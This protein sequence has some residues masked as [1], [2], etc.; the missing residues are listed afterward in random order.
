MT[1][2]AD[3]VRS[4]IEALGMVHKASPIGHV[5]VSIGVAATVP[6]SGQ[7]ASDLIEAADAGLYMAKRRGRNT[8]VEHSAIRM[9]DQVMALA[10]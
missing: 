8:V 9:V 5:T 10:G 3:L 1:E 7:N 4:R 2:V 6:A